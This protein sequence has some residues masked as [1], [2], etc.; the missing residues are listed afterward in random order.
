M[1]SKILD[2]TQQK[3][4][5]D[6]LYLNPLE[7]ELRGQSVDYAL[8][9]ID[10][11]PVYCLEEQWFINY[12]RFPDKEQKYSIIREYI[13]SPTYKWKKTTY[14]NTISLFHFINIWKGD[15]RFVRDALRENNN[16]WET[17]GVL[18]DRTILSPEETR[19][20]IKLLQNSAVEL[21]LRIDEDEEERNME[22][23]REYYNAHFA[24]GDSDVW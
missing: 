22:K 5:Y 12:R 9:F 2:C 21:F 16:W 8:K 7:L 18:E 4:S 1:N 11:Y 10:I 19:K 13:N 17:F 20:I 14:Y 23:D 15:E 24:E 3:K 6:N